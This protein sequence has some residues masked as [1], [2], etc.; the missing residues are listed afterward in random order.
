MSDF[1]LKNFQNFIHFL[2]L[3]FVNRFVN[4]CLNFSI[5]R[6]LSSRPFTAS[7]IEPV[8]SETIIATA[9]V[10]SVMPRAARCLVP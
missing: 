9:S 2:S 1:L 10:S 3:S 6:L 7:E 5:S 4:F 8:S